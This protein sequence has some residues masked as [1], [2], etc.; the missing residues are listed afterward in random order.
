MLT[1]TVS[2]KLLSRSANEKNSREAQ[3]AVRR[4]GETH[5]TR[6]EMERTD[7]RGPRCYYP[8]LLADQ[9][10]KL[11][12]LLCNYLSLSQFELA[13]ATIHGLAALNPDKALSCLKQLIFVGPPSDW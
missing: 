6:K 3:I 10:E 9:E 1:G 7:R 8:F 11:V 5:N 12:V 13:R 2:A 4:S